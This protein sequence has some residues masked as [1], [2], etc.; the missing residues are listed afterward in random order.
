[1]RINGYR[2]YQ[3]FKKLGLLLFIGILILG[4]WKL[5]RLWTPGDHQVVLITTLP[6]IKPGTLVVSPYSSEK[7]LGYSLGTTFQEDPLGKA[8]Q[9]EILIEKG[10]EDLFRPET[11][12]WIED[13]APSLRFLLSSLATEENS[14]HFQRDWKAVQES[15]QVQSNVF[16]E[17]FKQLGKKEFEK[18]NLS[19]EWDLLCQDEFLRMCLHTAIMEEIL[20]RID[21]WGLVTSGSLS[22]E[23]QKS[24]LQVK[25]QMQYQPVVK[26]ALRDA[27]SQ[28]F[29][30]V[31]RQGTSPWTWIF[32]SH[33][34]RLNAMKKE[35]WE[36]LKRGAGK[37]T[38]AQLSTIFKQNPDL[39]KNPAWAALEVLHQQGVAQN[40]LNFVSSLWQNEKLMT[41][42]KDRYGV[43]AKDLLKDVFLQIQDHPVAAT[44]IQEMIKKAEPLLLRWG[45]T[46]FLDANEEE[47]NPL[48]IAMIKEQLAGYHLPIIYVIPSEQGKPVPFHYVYDL[49]EKEK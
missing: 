2:C 48:L 36:G 43:R 47:M 27:L 11:S 20:Q 10:K 26:A 41:H 34:A 5:Y 19:R 24:V 32:Y 14:E 15:F 22:K 23:V 8:Y 12:I 38:A 18:A 13:T 4:G 39:Y 7:K 3:S 21:F 9:V 44:C 45:K 25:D 46:I 28:T 16:L 31:K 6:A 1:M 17:T 35:A 33:T 37:E 42:I 40:S 30:E 49:R 29:T